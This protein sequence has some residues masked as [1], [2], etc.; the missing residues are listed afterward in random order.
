MVKLLI[1]SETMD[2]CLLHIF[3]CSFAKKMSEDGL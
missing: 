2:L 3:F 1:Q